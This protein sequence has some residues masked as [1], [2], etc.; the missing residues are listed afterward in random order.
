MRNEADING[1]FR[2]W[3]TMEW[4]RIQINCSSFIEITEAS[5][6]IHSLIEGIDRK[7]STLVKF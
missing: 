6:I 5:K 1:L 3:F 7:E 4:Y 2:D